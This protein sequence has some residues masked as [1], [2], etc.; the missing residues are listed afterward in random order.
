MAANRQ[1]Y[2]GF[3]SETCE[4]PALVEHFTALKCRI[5][6]EEAP[7]QGKVVSHP[8]PFALC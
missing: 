2:F 4:K 6:R 5:T 3:D 7:H 1:G 8:M